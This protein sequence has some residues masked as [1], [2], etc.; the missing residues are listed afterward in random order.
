MQHMLDFERGKKI[1]EIIICESA[2]YFT[3]LVTTFL[4]VNICHRRALAIAFG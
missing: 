2:R 4:C 3:L 1:H